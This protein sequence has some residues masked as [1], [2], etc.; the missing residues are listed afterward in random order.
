MSAFRAAL[1]WVLVQVAIL[2]LLLWT[3]VDFPHHRVATGVAP[4]P[5]LQPKPLPH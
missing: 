5:A 4:A 1:I 2:G 3:G